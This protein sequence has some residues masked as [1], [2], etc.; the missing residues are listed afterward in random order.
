M[1]FTASWDTMLVCWKV[2]RSASGSKVTGWINSLF[3]WRDDLL[4]TSVVLL[5]I[6]GTVRGNPRPKICDVSGGSTSGA[7]LGVCTKGCRSEF[8]LVVIGLILV[9]PFNLEDRL[10]SSLVS[11]IILGTVPGLLFLVFR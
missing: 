9:L 8:G 1:K 4:G 7:I 11:F 10:G 3:L 6:L 2:V 5:R